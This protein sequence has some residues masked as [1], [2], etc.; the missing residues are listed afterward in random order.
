MGQ[1]G[2]YKGPSSTPL[3]NAKAVVARETHIAS[4]KTKRCFGGITT[5]GRELRPSFVFVVALGFLAGRR[6]SFRVAR[7]KHQKADDVVQLAR[8]ES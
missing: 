2:D 7:G 8:M 4:P 6:F 3:N 1:R 5:S